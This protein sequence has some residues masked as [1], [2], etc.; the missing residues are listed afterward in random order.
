MKLGVGISAVMLAAV[1]SVGCGSGAAGQARAPKTAGEAI[2]TT[3]ITSSTTP[4]LI[5]PK[6]DFDDVED[7]TEVAD[8]L[9]IEGDDDTPL[10]TWGVP[11]EPYTGPVGKYGF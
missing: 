8:L 11:P 1:L 4:R 9:G 7:T 6:I 3:T 2:G 5:L 10:Q